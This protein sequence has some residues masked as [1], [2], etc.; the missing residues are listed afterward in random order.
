M[1]G[2]P[3]Q[4]QLDKYQVEMLDISDSFTASIV[5]HEFINLDGAILENLGLKARTIKFK[6][7]WYAK[8][9]AAN[10]LTAATYANHYKFLEHITDSRNTLELTHPK[11]GRLT[12]KI[13][14]VSVIHNDTQDYCEI[15]IDFTEDGLKSNFR[16]VSS[17]DVDALVEAMAVKVNN[18]S[19][20]KMR[21][22]MQSLGMSDILAK[23]LDFS[24]KITAQVGK[25]SNTAHKFCRAADD[26]I[27]AFDNFLKDRKSVV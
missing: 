14:N 1:P 10:G 11:Y 24:Q 26:A 27:G 23:S 8:A 19:I 12:G 18:S 25:V 3:F 16:V 17:Q 22:R 9:T 2:S 7:F 21:A 15:D 4:A 20:S 6:T 13:P 5:Q